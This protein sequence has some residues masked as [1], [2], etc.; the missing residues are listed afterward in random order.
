MPDTP[1]CPQSNVVSGDHKQHHLN[2]LNG[3]FTV[4][5]QHWCRYA[6]NISHGCD[7]A[8]FG[9]TRWLP[10]A[11][12]LYEQKTRRCAYIEALRIFFCGQADLK[13]GYMNHLVVTR[14]FRYTLARLA[15]PTVRYYLTTG[16]LAGRPRS[17][18]LP[19]VLLDVGPHMFDRGRHS[20][21]TGLA[22]ENSYLIILND[23]SDLYG[24]LSLLHSDRM[25]STSFGLTASISLSYI[26]FP[27]IIPF[28]FPSFDSGS[29]LQGLLVKHPGSRHVFS[30]NIGHARWCTVTIQQTSF[31]PD[32]E[33]GVAMDGIPIYSPTN[34]VFAELSECTKFADSNPYPNP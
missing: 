4:F 22:L 33:M 12:N 28:L 16:C 26:T 34:L 20:I 2:G 31:L 32:V 21:R 19:S 10:P 6:I 5:P 27:Y 18:T 15:D 13:I 30:K 17:S 7:A 8:A 11:L 29:T 25:D 24:S 1:I 9:D 3:T 23:P 14:H